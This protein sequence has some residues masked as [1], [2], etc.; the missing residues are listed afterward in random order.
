[1]KILRIIFCTLIF[2][3]I[4]RGQ[5]ASGSVSA[6]SPSVGTSKEPTSARPDI[7]LKNGRVLKNASISS[8]T[9]ATV[10]VIYDDGVQTFSWEEMPDDLQKKYNFNKSDKEKFIA[11][12]KIEAEKLAQNRTVREAGAQ[13][14]AAAS[15]EPSDEEQVNQY[16]LSHN[17]DIVA[18]L[19]KDYKDNTLDFK[20]FKNYY[21]S[22]RDVN[23]KILISVFGKPDYVDTDVLVNGF[24]ENLHTSAVAFFGVLKSDILKS[25]KVKL[26]AFLNTGQI[27]DLSKIIMVESP[28]ESS[29]QVWY[30][31]VHGEE[32]ASVMR[33]RLATLKDLIQGEADKDK[34]LRFEKI[35]SNFLPS[36]DPKAFDAINVGSGNVVP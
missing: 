3:G 4:V 17:D 22:L 36:T 32:A 6:K 34:K 28:E 5:S 7:I 25:G 18:L 31:N 24:G 14:N 33:C 16:I 29:D 8:Y 20:K 15:S 35:I 2:S 10:V 21:G 19:Q 13:A 11:Q 12:S 26:M 30:A 9:P 23:Y 27:S 1:M